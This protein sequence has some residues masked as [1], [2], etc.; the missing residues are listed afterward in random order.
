MAKSK[1]LEPVAYHEAGHAVILWRW[2]VPLQGAVTI[3]PDYEWG[4]AGAVD[5]PN[6]D[7]DDAVGSERAY[8]LEGRIASQLAGY[9]AEKRYTGKRANYRGA[10]YDL[11]HA[12]FDCEEAINT[13]D[14]RVIGAYLKYMT[15][16]VQELLDR[17]DI[18]A[19]VTGLATK[20]LE[21]RTLD[22]EEAFAV[23]IA[24]HSR[25]FGM[26]PLVQDS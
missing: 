3:V 9:L 16:R 23:I 21:R 14:E 7:M 15:L 17:P 26:E 5:L 10:N 2:D 1:A 25:H 6:P 19:A 13:T 20:L 12:R 8:M 18:W 22:A 11:R 4:S 24:A